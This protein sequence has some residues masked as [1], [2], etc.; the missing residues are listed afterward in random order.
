VKVS[1]IEV[2]AT[3]VNRG[4]GK[5]T[6]RVISIG[7]DC[8]PDEWYGLHPRPMEPGVLF[9]Q[10]GKTQR[11]YLSSFASWAGAKVSEP[12]HFNPLAHE[13]TK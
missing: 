1:D 13:Q 6:R 7:G 8:I 11:M 12:V 4:A 9:V 10:K 5:T 2:G 3:Y